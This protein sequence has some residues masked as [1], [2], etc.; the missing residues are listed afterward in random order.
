M[1][2]HRTVRCILL[3]VMAVLPATMLAQ[4]ERLQI[5]ASYSILGDV[6]SN[7][8]GD[9]A[10]V[11]LTMPVGAD[12]HSFEPVPSDI[13]RLAEADVVFTNGAFFEEGLLEAIENADEGM[14]IIEV[15]ACVEIIPIGASSH[16]DH[17][18]EGEHD[19]EEGEDHDHE[20][21]EAHSDEE[22]E[23]VAMADT[24]DMSAMATRC[25]EHL[26][27]FESY[28]EDGEAH[29]DDEMAEGE[30]HEDGDHH[31][32]EGETLGRLFEIDCGEGH[33][34]EHGEEGHDEDE[35]HSDDEQGH[36]HGEGSCDSH[37]WMEP[38]NVMYWTMM[39]RDTLIEMDPAN[40]ETYTANAD[41]YLT[42]L[43]ELV[44]DFVIPLVETLPEEN[45]I[46]VTSHDSLGYLAAR[47][48]F[49]L[50]GTIIPNGS[51]LAEPSTQDVAA[52]IDIINEEGVPAIFGETTVS[53]GVA[54][55]IA[56]ETG[57]ELL[58]LYSGTL[59]DS[60]GPAATYVDY[61]RYN[62]TTI[63]DALVG[64]M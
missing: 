54:Q 35:D 8:V 51:T 25:D 49:E 9:V 20:E 62:Y 19:H 12:P 46:L 34:H 29:N 11:T 57:A 1:R 61:I 55:V 52:V 64:G 27:E 5:V 45:R 63:V 2:I 38:H 26:V 36:E 7:V 13:V 58:V 50:V 48:E 18:E 43:D 60:D 24:S 15:S 4:E 32:S 30:D 6:V 59:S 40:A 14:N 10:D 44:H 56:D 21:G 37:V 33:G 3:L 16:D 53:D 17:D 39:I 28:H 42:T 41:A 22:G 47:F 31:H 23:S